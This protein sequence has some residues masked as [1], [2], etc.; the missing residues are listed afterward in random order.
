MQVE[1]V[2]ETILRNTVIILRRSSDER[3]PVVQL[4][5]MVSV[6]QD[7]W[8]RDK[9]ED[10]GEVAWGGHLRWRRHPVRGVC[11][12]GGLPPGE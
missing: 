7:L 6:Q 10:Q 5:P 2:Q 4:D 8:R 3:M 1:N 9:D 12:A 11:P